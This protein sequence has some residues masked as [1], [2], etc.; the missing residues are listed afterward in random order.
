M[1]NDDSPID[2]DDDATRAV[3]EHAPAPQ[4]TTLPRHIAGLLDNLLA[5]VVSVLIAKQLPDSQRGL[6][7]AAFVVSYLGY[8]LLCEGLFHTTLAKAVNGLVVRDV[9]GGRCTFRQILV[10]TLFR[11]LECN[12][13]LLGFAPAAARIILSRDK[14]RFGDKAAG[15]VVVFR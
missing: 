7:A 9:R 11:I 6:Q 15:T 10:R 4:G 8:F 13:L 5:W 12:P 14:Q 2:D 3:G 1:R